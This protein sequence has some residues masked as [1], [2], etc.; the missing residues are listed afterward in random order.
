MDLPRTVAAPWLGS[1]RVR[2]GTYRGSRREAIDTFHS[3]FWKSPVVL[4]N[5]YLSP[6]SVLF[7]A[8]TLF[9]IEGRMVSA[10]DPSRTHKT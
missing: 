7:S 1:S 2:K 6:L 5:L 10:L 8:G 4:V 3:G 9:C